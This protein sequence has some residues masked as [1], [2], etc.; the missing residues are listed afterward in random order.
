MEAF[1]A[2]AITAAAVT[3]D[4]VHPA[5]AE[6][7]EEEVEVVEPFPDAKYDTFYSLASIRRNHKHQ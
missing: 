6:E 5:A 7:G 1:K 3:E 4:E 2:A